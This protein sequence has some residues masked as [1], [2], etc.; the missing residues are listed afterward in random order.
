MTVENRR[1]PVELRLLGGFGLTIGEQALDMT[2]AAQRLL[3]FI[4]LTPRGAERSYTAF[5][6]WPEHD[7][8]RAKANL[9]S[10]LWR[11]GKAPAELIR[12]TKSRLR[13]AP[14]VWVDVRDGI[15]QVASGG[16]DSIVEAA[17]PFHALDSD[18]LPDWYDDWLMIERERLRQFRLGSLEEGARFAIDRA[19]L[20]LAIQLALAAVS[21]DPLRESGHRLVIEAHLANGNRLDA[22]RQLAC[23]R[24]LLRSQVGC[25]PSDRLAALVA[26]NGDGASGQRLLIAV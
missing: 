9:R 25:E 23:Y 4:A 8:R 13:L 2:P 20:G 18:L 12:A 15:A 11:L 26:G 17:L 3:A 24:A 5:Q 19:Q 1:V 7:E 21:I 10:A 16:L 14:G 6:L 22:E